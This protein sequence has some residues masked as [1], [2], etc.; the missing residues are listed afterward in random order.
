MTI[1]GDKVTE[2]TA[3][4]YAYLDAGGTQDVVEIVGDQRKKRLVSAFF[5]LVNMTQNGTLRVSYK[6]DASNYRIVHEH[7]WVTTDPDGVLLD[8]YPGVFSDVKVTYTE[9]VDE[10]A[11]RNI[12]YEVLMEVIG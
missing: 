8:R 10:G 6:I 12:P 4:T 1:I 7:A 9:A 3:G 5:D 2:R 11:D